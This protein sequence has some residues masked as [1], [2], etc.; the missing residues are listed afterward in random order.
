MYFIKDSRSFSREETLGWKWLHLSIEMYF[1]FSLS[2][3]PEYIMHRQVILSSVY[4]TCYAS[5]LN[6][7]TER[8]DKKLCCL[9]RIISVVWSLLK[10]LFY[11]TVKD[12]VWR[13]VFVW[14]GVFGDFLRFAI[15]PDDFQPII[16]SLTCSYYVIR[17][18]LIWLTVLQPQQ[19]VI[20]HPLCG[21]RCLLFLK[22][23]SFVKDFYKTVGAVLVLLVFFEGVGGVF[24]L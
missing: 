12:Y 1:S 8:N 18:N 14:F 19:G 16:K 24:P 23:E 20:R 21:I 11:G 6:L 13:V 5:L 9:L 2:L 15:S 10:Y 4:N 7:K 22:N 17:L 3:S